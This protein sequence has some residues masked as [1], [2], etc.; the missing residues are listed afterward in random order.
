MALTDTQEVYLY[1][2]LEVPR[3]SAAFL[4]TDPLDQQQNS[5]YCLQMKFGRAEEPV[6]PKQGYC[7]P[8]RLSDQSFRLYILNPSP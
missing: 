7:A 3:G 5:M 6:V 8:A 4:L 1:M 2:I